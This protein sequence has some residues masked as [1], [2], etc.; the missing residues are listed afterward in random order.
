MK[1]AFCP[2]HKLGHRDG[3]WHTFNSV[4]YKVLLSNASLHL[5]TSWWPGPTAAINS[6]NHH[7]PAETTEQSSVSSLLSST[8]WLCHFVVGK[9]FSFFPHSH[10][11]TRK[12]HRLKFISGEPMLS[13]Q[14]SHYF[15]LSG[16]NALN[17]QL[18]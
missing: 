14:S 15:F 3:C 17:N 9:D 18:D 10:K 4:K 16:S 12:P 2:Q 11:L 1:H 6:S 13:R 8:F 7:T 5:H